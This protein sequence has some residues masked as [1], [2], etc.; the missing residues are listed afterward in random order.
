LKLTIKINNSVSDCADAWDVLLPEQHHLQSK[1]LS[2]F[3]AANIA[4]ISCC[5]LQVFLNN[6]PCGVVYLQQFNFKLKHIN[7]SQQKKWWF[8]CVKMLLPNQ[9]PLLICGHLFRIGF[10]GYYFTNAANNYLVFDA[11][12]QYLASTAIK[13]WGVLVK[14]C[15]TIFDAPH[16]N[17]YN[18]VYFDG[19][20]TMELQCKPNWLNFDDYLNQL[21]KKYKQRAK[22]ILQALD[23]IEDCILNADEINVNTP[24]IEK[25][26][27]N[28]VNKQNV[29]LGTVNA[30][31]FI[32]LQQNLGNNF[33]F[34]ALYKNNIMV[35]F[36]TFIFYGTEMETHFIGLDYEANITNKL[37]FNILFLAVKKMIE[38]N[39]AKCE[40]GRTAK[41]AKANAGAQPKQ[42][43]NYVNS[44]NMIVR[45]LLNYFLRQFNTGESYGALERSPFK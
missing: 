22:K 30:K 21:T 11:I 28:V 27:W 35:G 4:D 36:Y 26:Y 43:V 34:H 10:E 31:Y 32:A 33:E 25:L 29:K 9:I 16:Y 17:K 41:E 18:Y 2:A 23:E 1:N 6:I 13:P 8:H 39:Y 20:V 7:F 24:A 44:R 37:Y 3:E 15:K 14:D 38:G 40:L 12:E 45:Y 5:Y 42:V 19:D